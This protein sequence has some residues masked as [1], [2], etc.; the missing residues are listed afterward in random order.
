MHS[1]RLRARSILATH[2]AALG[3]GALLATGC[4]SDGN[5][6]AT[7][8]ASAGAEPPRS[9][10]P[11]D[12]RIAGGPTP[13]QPAGVAAPA[14]AP[15][16]APIAPGRSPEEA[17]AGIGPVVAQPGPPGLAPN[18]A[19]RADSRG[20]IVDEVVGQINGK[21]VFATA[22][23]EEPKARLIALARDPRI[24]RERWREIAGAAIA[25]ELRTQ[26]ENELVLAEARAIL[27]PEQR[28]GLLAFVSNLREGL[29]AELGGAS[30]VAS[31][32]LF[33]GDS[34]IKSPLERRVQEKRDEQLVGNLMSREVWPRVQV[35]WREIQNEYERNLDKFQPSNT[36]SVRLLR[37]PLAEPDRVARLE[38]AVKANVPVAEIAASADNA[39]NPDTG[40]VAGTVDLREPIR[41]ERI[42]PLK[43]LQDAAAGIGPGEVRG[44]IRTE[45][46]AWWVAVDPVR[47]KTVTLEEAQLELGR[48]ILQRKYRTQQEAYIRR[49]RESGS[50]TQE[51]LMLARLLAI[52][53]ER[54][55][56]PIAG[57]GR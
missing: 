18:P 21:P 37:A 39:F 32:R 51:D 54:F 1:G 12:F 50:R 40:G 45:R 49:L 27:T 53:T 52:A 16:R 9:L 22:F 15:A 17:R 13:A 48:S 33:E 23:L 4:A 28:Q 55:F 6:G 42:S 44:P 10:S 36:A 5:P 8:S 2:G 11:A 30:E 38:A 35:S 26:I 24:S 29:A 25:S 31:Q 56:D 43:A 46:D 57:P 19:A 14:T 41:P 3:I 47:T 34:E 20:V 7:A